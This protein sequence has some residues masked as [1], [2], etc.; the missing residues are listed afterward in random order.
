[1]A[2][3]ST[4]IAKE[5]Y[6]LRKNLLDLTL[7]N[8]LLNFKPRNKTL[9]ITNQS[10]TN[11]YKTLVLQDYTMTFAPNKKEEKDSFKRYYGS[12]S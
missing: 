12:C 5:F 3:S 11:V 7:R 1:M 8:Q 4:K 10:P 2:S 6:N 9:T